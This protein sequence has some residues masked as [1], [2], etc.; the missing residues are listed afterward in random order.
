[1][2]FLRRKHVPF[3]VLTFLC[4]LPTFAVENNVRR[5]HFKWMTIRTPHFDIYYDKDTEAIVPRM[6][7]YLEAAWADVGKAYNYYVPD[8]T[9]FFF[10]SNH[11]QFEQTNIVPI[12]EGTGGVTEAFKNRL[13][14]FNDGSEEWLRHVIY[15]EFTH[16]MQFNILYGGWWKSIRLLKSPFYPLWMMEGSAEFGSGDIDDATGDMVVRDAYAHNQLPPLAELQGFAHLKPNQVTL[17]YKTG[18]AAITFLKEEYGEEKLHEFMFAMKDFFDVSSALQAV[19]GCDLNWFDFRFREWVGEKY[20]A[21]YK[22]A[23]SPSA[24]GQKLT[25]SDLIPQFNQNPVVSPDGKKIYFFSDRGGPEQLMELNLDTSKTKPIL[26][27]KYN[28]YEYLHSGGRGLSISPDGRWLAFSA[29]K[30]QRDYLYIYDLKKHKAKRY[31]IPFDEIRFPV[32]SPVDNDRLVCTGMTRGVNDLYLIDRKARLIERLTNTPQ[33]ERNPTFT[34]DGKSIVFSGEVMSEDLSEPRYRNLFLLDIQTKQLRQITDHVGSELEPEVLPDGSIV[35][36]R[37]R[38]DKETFGFNLYHRD[39][40]GHETR[41]TNFIG[42]GFSPRY[43]AANHALY[44]V[45]FDAGE[46][47][48]YKG[49]WDLEKPSQNEKIIDAGLLG[50]GEARKQ[51]SRPIL[52]WPPGKDEPLFST[53]GRPYRFKGSTDL[54]IPFFFYS[55]VDGFV[56]MDVWQ[57]SDLLGNHVFQ[58]Q[59][60]YASGGNTM[61]LSVLYTYARFRPSFSIGVHS[62]RYYR[63]FTQDSQRREVSGFGLVTYPLDRVSSVIAGVGVTDREDVFF[64]GSEPDTNFHDRFGLAGYQYD[65]VTGRYLIPTKGQRLGVTYQQGASKLGGDQSYKTGLIEGVQYFPI[66]GESTLATRLFYGRSIGEE[67]QVFRLGGIDK[68]RGVSSGSDANKKSNVALGSA[69]LRLRIKY[70]N[71]RTSFLFPDFFFKA[72]YL[73]VFEDAGYGWDSTEERNAFDATKLDN[74]AGLGVSWPTF[75]L[76]SFQLNLT[77]QWAH[78]TDTGGDVWYISVAPSF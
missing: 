11:N 21:L 71:T 34:P 66:P 28:L 36:V 72:A 42:G 7:H 9:P 56:V 25:P 32:F 41:L 77:V 26:P 15:H 57:Y 64:D 60:Q 17:G 20:A 78:R 74:S 58:Q 8:R 5:D 49:T 29:E 31:A 61:D 2:S 50:E 10:Y 37:D 3:F 69:E 44:Y 45:G 76:Q 14:I 38:D 39:T 40:A 55:S 33:D 4:T 54:F 43:S 62:L 47:H 23:A 51:K 6:A 65:T 13:V 53:V 59:A 46:K 52:A 27:L 35:Y 67:K 16:V 24:Y 48:I 75:I 19:I 73:I 30:E 18:D 1:M 12:G 68:I 70:L 63:D 22:D